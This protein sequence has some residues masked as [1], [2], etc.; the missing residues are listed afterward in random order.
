METIGQIAIKLVI[1]EPGEEQQQYLQK[2]R[3]YG[4]KAICS[5]VGS[6]QM[7][8]VIASIETASRREGIISD[9]YRDEHALYHSILDALAGVC[10]G[11][12]ALDNV[13]RT[14]GIKYS[15]IIGPKASDHSR[16]DY[17]LVVAIYGTIGAPIKG[18]EHE[19]IGLGTYHI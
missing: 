16:D 13:L 2:I 11:Q 12:L 10:R 5:Q 15:V 7:E 14:V 9:T 17:W 1:T 3:G 6:M 19:A 8:K 4:Y 18:F